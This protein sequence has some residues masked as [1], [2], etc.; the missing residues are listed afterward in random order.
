MTSH[1]TGPLLE[2]GEPQWAAVEGQADA[3]WLF[4]AHNGLRRSHCGLFLHREL[5]LHHPGNLPLCRRCA[6]RHRAPQQRLGTNIL[7]WLGRRAAPAGTDRVRR[8]G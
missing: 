4:I 6:S 7:A 5:I 1:W 3:H 8:Q 2:L